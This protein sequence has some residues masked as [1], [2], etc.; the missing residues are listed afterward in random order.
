MTLEI[1]KNSNTNTLHIV[2]FLDINP[3]INMEDIKE[4]FESIVNKNKKH[5]SEIRVWNETTN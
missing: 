4:Y 5:N 1:Y 2:G 3:E